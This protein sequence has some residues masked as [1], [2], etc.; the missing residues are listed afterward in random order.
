MSVKGSAVFAALSV[1]W[2]CTYLFI[3]VAVDGGVPPAGVAF[4]RVGLGAAI[5]LTVSP[6]C[7]RL[8]P[9]R[10]R[11]RALTVF[12][13]VDIA[14]PFLL[15][16]LV[17][18]HVTSSLAAVAIAASPLILAALAFG[19]DRGDRP[20]VRRAAGLVL[21]FG[22]VAVLV[23][24]DG[25]DHPWASLGLLAAA[26]GYAV[27][28][29]VLKR[30][31]LGVD[32]TLVM[33]AALGISAAALAPAALVTAPSTMPSTAALAAI[34]A[35]GVLCT[36]AAYVLYGLL[37]REVGA[38]R[39]IVVTYLNPLVAVAIAIPLVGERPGLGLV[40][41]MLLIL[42]G[43]WLATSERSGRRAPPPPRS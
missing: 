42:P 26:T 2:G 39:A 30:R 27:G 5:L 43:S 12:A 8:A 36:A 35:M 20:T 40:L 14:V 33:G 22:G 16:A 9:L 38:G 3:K 1:I 15:V 37:I 11:W 17:E 32:T 25:V 6:R 10:G 7:R 4:L 41:G 19:Y 28:P 23:G 18:R 21:G 24:F 31:L 13:M 34:L 29:L